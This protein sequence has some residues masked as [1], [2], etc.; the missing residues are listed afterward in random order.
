MKG[1]LGSLHNGILQIGGILDWSLDITLADSVRDASI[2]YK[3]A[4]WKV[5]AQ[6]YWLF[7][8]PNGP[9]IIRLYPDVGTGYWQGE[10]IVGYPQK[11]FDTLI[12]AQI[13]LIGSG[14][15][16]GKR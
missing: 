15:L 9:I 10:G 7:D 2:F 16:E 1:R 8:V 14:V 13:E 5:T 4:G 3:L 11:I 12:H 6:S